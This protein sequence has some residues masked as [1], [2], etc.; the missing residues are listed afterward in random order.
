MPI[1]DSSAFPS[2]MGFSSFS[3]REIEQFQNLA[4]EA[5][6]QEIDA[7]CETLSISA[8]KI[9]THIILFNLESHFLRLDCPYMYDG[10]L[11]TLGI[12]SDNNNIKAKARNL[13]IDRHSRYFITVGESDSMS[14]LRNIR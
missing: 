5:C 6:I 10:F 13:A 7:A 14:F 8:G 11:M 9:S 1:L 12:R 4:L 2:A 3:Y